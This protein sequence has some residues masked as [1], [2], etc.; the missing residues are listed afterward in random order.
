VVSEPLV[1]EIDRGESADAF[2]K[3]VCNAFRERPDMLFFI[4]PETKERGASERASSTDLRKKIKLMEFEKKVVTQC[5]KSSTLKRTSGMLFT[6]LA[7]KF[8]A[9]LG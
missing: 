4:I 5:C 3:R 9:K 7:L 6:N 8:N 2:L 1:I